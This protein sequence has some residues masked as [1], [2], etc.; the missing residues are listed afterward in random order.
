MERSALIVI[1]YDK[2]IEN[3]FVELSEAML[4]QAGRFKAKAGLEDAQ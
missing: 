2:A 4:K 3:G 1:D